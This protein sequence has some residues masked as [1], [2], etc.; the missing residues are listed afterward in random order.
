MEGPVAVERP[1]GREVRTLTFQQ[2]MRMDWRAR[3]EPLLLCHLMS[4]VADIVTSETC[5]S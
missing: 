5:H 3:G 4:V 2:L 1:R